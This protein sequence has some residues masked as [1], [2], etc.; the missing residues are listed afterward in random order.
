MNKR[1]GLWL[2]RAGAFLLTAAVLLTGYNI[3]DEQRAAS[4]TEELLTHFMTEIPEPDRPDAIPDYLLNPDMEMPTVEIDGNRYI[5]LIE[6]PS[7]DLIL[8]VISTCDQGKLKIAPCRYSGTAYK[9]G[10]VIA[11][12]NYRAH[13]LRI[14]NLTA[15]DVVEFIDIDGN[16][17]EYTVAKSEILDPYAVEEMTAPDWDL[18]LF[19]CTYGGGERYTVR[20]EKGNAGVVTDGENK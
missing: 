19:T 12:H 2:M 3:W 5:G 18:T 13:F 15:G 16:R 9:S 6:I 4:G 1:K 17:F 11:G 8:P 14:R 20:C 10:F 7:L